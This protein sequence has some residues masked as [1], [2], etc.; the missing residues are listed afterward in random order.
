MQAFNMSNYGRYTDEETADQPV[1]SYHD[2]PLSEEETL[3]PSARDSLQHTDM[4]DPHSRPRNHSWKARITERIP[5]R[6]QRYWANTVEWVKGPDPPRIFSINPIFP[7]IQHAPLRLLDRYAPK[8][9]QRFWLL[10]AFYACWLFAFVLIQ[11]KSSFAEEVAGY[12]APVRLWCGAHYW[13][14]RND[15]GINGDQCRPFSNTTFAFRCPA[16]CARAQTYTPHAVGDQE[17]VYQNI[18][19]GGPTNMSDPISSSIY[20]GDSYICGAAIH[21]GFINDAEGGCGVLELIGEQQEFPAMKAH[22]ISSTG[23]D[24]YFPQSFT[25]KDGTQQVCKDLRWPVVV[26]SVIA[27]FVLGIFTTSPAVFFWSIVVCLFFVTGLA[28]DPP[29]LADYYS[30]ISMATGRF[31]PAA[32]CM[33]IMYKYAV[34]RTLDNL[35]AQF[36]K[37]ILWLG[38]AWVGALNNYTFD[39]IPIQRLTPHDLHA[40]PGAIPAL[41]IIVLSIFC[42]ALGQAWSFR[43]E[44]RMPKY[45]LLYTIL[46]ASL[47]FLL[48]IPKMNLRIHHYILALLF[49]PG[50]SFQNRPS[51]IYQGLLVGLFV[52]GIARWGFD[53]ILQTP[54]EILKDV[55]IGSALPVIHAPMVALNNQITF[56]LG[57]LPF[58]DSD[59]IKYD[60]ISVLVNDVE[61]LRTY[62]DN[63][64]KGRWQ[65]GTREWTWNR[66]VEGLPEYFR[67]AYMQGS[68][69]VDYTKA[70]TWFGNGSWVEMA[71]GASK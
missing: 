5:P 7:S 34:H 66:H 12:G 63:D 3:L 21:A 41:I 19:V 67:F 31:L 55:N 62:H 8:K 37:S 48:A 46:V 45:L 30:L 43:V 18:V 4:D 14:D 26:V 33:A 2:D 39:R 47:L 9:A 25:F 42:I 32:F 29:N 52:N 69:A 24:S 49:L 58:T 13:N 35:T 53:S 71:E 22:S 60:G 16:N 10:V 44:G 57:P 11:W 23:F 50:T 20:R 38:P 17:V 68:S 64:V 40:Q 15:C 6:V 70:G 27:T 56:T 28:T 36:E 51:L 65:N 61:R 54:G 59:E 1:E